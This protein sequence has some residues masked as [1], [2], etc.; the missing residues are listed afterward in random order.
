MDNPKAILVGDL[1]VKADLVTQKDLNEALQI[2]RETWMPIGRVLIVSNMLTEEQL[3]AAVAAQSLL[4]DGLITVEQA[5]QAVK[6]ACREGIS[7]EEALKKRGWTPS[8]DKRTKLGDLLLAS[9][10]LSKQELDEALS[11]CASTGLPMGRVLVLMGKLSEQLL[12]TAV[13]SQIMIRDNKVTFEQAAEGL[14]AARKRQPQPQVEPQP[15]PNYT[16]PAP[17][18]MRLGELLA[19][20]GLLSE[21]ELMNALEIG[22]LNQKPIGQ[23]LVELGYTSQ[24]ILE[25]A[26]NLQK[27]IAGNQFK[28]HDAAAVLAKV[29]QGAELQ[30]AVNQLKAAK[31]PQEEPLPIA[32][33]LQGAGTISDE[34]I[35]RAIE[36]GLSNS[37]MMGRLLLVAGVIDERTLQ[38]ALRCIFLHRGGLLTVEQ[39]KTVFE[40]SRR[41]DISVDET[42]QQL[43][44]FQQAPGKTP[45]PD[46]EMQW[47]KA[48]T[49]GEKA[50]NEGNLPAAEAAWTQ[51]LQMAEHLG[52]RDRRL[53]VSIDALADALWRQNKIQH[54]EALLRRS[55][56][57]TTNVLGPNHYETATR[58]NKLAEFYYTQANYEKV[59]P[60]A[61]K[62]LD[63]YEQNLGPEHP[64]VAWLLHNLA[65]LYHMQDSFLKAETFYQRALGIRRKTLGD[66]HPETTRLLKSYAK[67]LKSMHRDD[68]AEHLMQAATGLITGSWKAI[69]PPAEPLMPSPQDY[70]NR[71]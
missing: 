25:A 65:T 54:I 33:F 50:M 24:H 62:L 31:V 59:E 60:L 66:E 68:E 64:T 19:M 17:Q 14:K 71:D 49:A 26:L 4:K 53:V 8:E 5:V 28:P 52:E 13:N 48:K 69:P 10:L 67:L 41:H 45:P 55:V 20:A 6:T 63:L 38:S 36:V 32:Q 57:I 39:A 2:A 61:L 40:H 21:S 12:T 44:W 27:M 70:R 46:L 58:M 1:V 43:G 30:E 3:Q 18:T 11:R 51:A 15:E 29:K 22:L 23:V 37:Q 34:D 47:E 7:C 56:D 16:Y 35:R 42:L 9:D